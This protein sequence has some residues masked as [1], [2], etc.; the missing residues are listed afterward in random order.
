MNFKISFFQDVFTIVEE[1]TG[2]CPGVGLPDNFKIDKNYYVLFKELQQKF[3]L[4]KIFVTD[5]SKV[6]NLPE[7]NKIKKIIDLYKSFW[8]KQ[9]E[10]LFDKKNYLKN[11]INFNKFLEK[12]Q[13]TTKHQWKTKE[14]IVFLTIGYKDSGTYDR[15]INVIRLGIHE[16]KE[17]YLTY[18][19]YHELIHYHI[20]N[21]MKIL[22]KKE[23]E[24]ILCR[25]I[26]SIVFKD[27]LIAQEHWR[28][29]ISEDMIKKINEKSLQF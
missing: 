28:E 11:N 13:K 15:E 19:L 27:N 4:T 22:L 9:K 23:D 8:E 29:N 17:Q 16:N 24:E 12:L 6:K 3:N 26:F 7:W 14:L 20:V 21:N 10:K 18:T 2:D 1:L 5:F 25:A